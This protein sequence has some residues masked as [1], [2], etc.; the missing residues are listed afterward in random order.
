MKKILAAALL[1]AAGPA[2]AQLY[3]GASAGA[4]RFDTG[5]VCA[6]A[7]DCDRRDRG[8]R[9]YAGLRLD[10]D[11]SLEVGAHDFGQARALSATSTELA[12]ARLRGYHVLLANR[13]NAG[14]PWYLNSRI[15]VGMNRVERSASGLAQEEEEKADLYLGIGAAWQMSPSLTLRLDLDAT[16]GESAGRRERVVLYSAGLELEF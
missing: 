12:S 9:A 15:G 4:T 6:A 11:W 10:P 1:L 14:H 7:A 16:R 13:L 5:V 8:G 2:M 3:V